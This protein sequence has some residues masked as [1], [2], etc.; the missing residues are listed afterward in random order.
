MTKRVRYFDRRKGGSEGL[1]GGLAGLKIVA[2]KVPA[3]MDRPMYLPGP[4]PR[5]YVPSL[6][7]SFP[8]PP[9]SFIYLSSQPL[10]LVHDYGPV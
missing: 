2:G 6:P 7:S 9:S 3:F 5:P 1:G 8:I 4:D 10:Q